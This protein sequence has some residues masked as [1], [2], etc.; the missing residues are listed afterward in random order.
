MGR[1]SRIVRT[2]V[3]LVVGAV[4]LLPV[5]LL[6]INASKSPLTYVSTGSW[7]PREF[8]L[9]PNMVEALKLSGLADSVLT[10]VVY[11][12]VS[13]TIAVII[14]AA[15]GFAIVALHLRHGFA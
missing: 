2:T 12:I 10:T 8:D 14:G 5:Y 7:I 6:V 11:T 9:I 1:A 13:P 15:A 3:L 4:W